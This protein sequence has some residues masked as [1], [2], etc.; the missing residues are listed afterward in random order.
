M[1]KRTLHPAL[2][3]RA[4]AVKQAHAHLSAT[5]PNFSQLHPHDRTRMVHA[6]IGK[7]T[8]AYLKAKGGC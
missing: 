8:G 4:T 6:H 3:A 1:A 2:K 5:V 7:N